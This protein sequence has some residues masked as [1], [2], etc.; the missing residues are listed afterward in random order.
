MIFGV[1]D[2]ICGCCCGFFCEWDGWCSARSS[3]VIHCCEHISSNSIHHA[4]LL[5][6]TTTGHFVCR[7][8]SGWLLQRL[9]KGNNLTA[10]HYQRNLDL[11]FEHRT[12]KKF[13]EGSNKMESITE[14]KLTRYF[15][16][17][18]VFHAC[19]SGTWRWSHFNGQL[20]WGLLGH[21]ITNASG[22]S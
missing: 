2:I 5:H 15:I 19:N 18:H 1:P 3:T 9:E 21:P 17:L 10:N 11:S 6:C 8:I 16:W 20:L 12:Y 22:R 7:G 14:T 13:H 4:D